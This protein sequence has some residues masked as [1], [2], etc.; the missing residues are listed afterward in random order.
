VLYL[1]LDFDMVEKGDAMGAPEQESWRAAFALTAR[2][3]LIYVELL[4]IIAILR[5]D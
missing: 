5:G 1:I 2:L 4:R 3:V